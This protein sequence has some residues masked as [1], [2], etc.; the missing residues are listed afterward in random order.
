MLELRNAID[1]A[2]AHL[3]EVQIERPTVFGVNRYAEGPD[4]CEKEAPLNHLGDLFLIHLGTI[5][6]IIK[7]LEKCSPD[8][9]HPD[10]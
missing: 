7:A 6:V 10:Y 2:I 4:S 5:R 1:F 9:K 3:L 8:S